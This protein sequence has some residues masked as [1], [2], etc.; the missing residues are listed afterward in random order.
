[1]VSQETG[2]QSLD[3]S[4][5]L[6]RIVPWSHTLVTEV[7][8]PGDTVVDLTAGQGRDTLVLALAV[9]LTGRVVAFDVQKSALEQAART[10]RVAGFPVTDWK[11]GADVPSAPGIYLVHAC[12]TTLAAFVTTPIRAAI[13]NLGYLPGGDA[14]LTTHPVTTCRAL[15]AALDLLLPGGRLVVTVY[16]G[17]P[18]G[19][20][21]ADAVN[22]LLT[23]LPCEQWHV[24]RLSVANVAGA[25]Y[26]L[27]AE[28]TDR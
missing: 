14:S 5:C 12:H 23:G 16:P 27:L 17:H 8:E 18:G 4:P 2:L 7:L 24:L 13:A 3:A 22:A 1:M 10:L 28:R 19:D 20:V 6:T 21:E 11:L 15:R 9:G 26:L 25:P